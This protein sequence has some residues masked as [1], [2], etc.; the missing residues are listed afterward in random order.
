MRAPFNSFVSD[1]QEIR[2]DKYREVISFSILYITFFGGKFH[3]TNEIYGKVKLKQRKIKTRYKWFDDGW[4]Y[5]EY[6][7]LWQYEWKTIK[8]NKL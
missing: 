8:I 5:Q 4:T 7:S 3:F 1:F 2:L 6:W